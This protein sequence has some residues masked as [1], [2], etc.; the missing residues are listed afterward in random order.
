MNELKE[1]LNKLEN[2]LAKLAA[3]YNGTDKAMW[4]PI[5]VELLRRIDAL[6]A[7]ITKAA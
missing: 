2:E 7:Q 5:K 1:R 4:P 3:K 6:K